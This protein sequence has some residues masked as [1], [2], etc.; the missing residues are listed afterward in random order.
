MKAIVYHTSDRMTDDQRIDTMF[1][2]RTDHHG[3]CCAKLF[4]QNLYDAVA[5]V[6]DTGNLELIYMMTNSFKLPWTDPE[7][8]AKRD[9]QVLTQDGQ[10]RS[11]SVGDIV[12]LIGNN[13]KTTIHVV[14]SVGFEDITDAVDAARDPRFTPIVDA[15]GL[16]M[17]L[18]SIKSGF[19]SGEDR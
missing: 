7:L 13:G 11:T 15:I 12:G 6:K 10:A 4:A 9:I 19:K 17:K 8:T 14:A 3:E 18:D 1:G 16:A 2:F 5:V